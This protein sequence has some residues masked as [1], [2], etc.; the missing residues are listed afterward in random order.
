MGDA[1]FDI[2]LDTIRSGYDGRTCWVHPR[3]GAIPASH[4]GGV[5]IVVMT[6]QKLLLSGFDIFDAL[7]EMRT[8]DLGRSW[9][10]P[11]E[12]RT[13]SRRQH[14]HDLQ[15]CPCDFTPKWHAATKTLL[16]TGATALYDARNN[17][18]P[19]AAP[20]RPS[21][22]TYDAASRSWREWR[23]L[24][25][26]DTPEF[27]CTHAGCTQRVDRSDGTIFLPVHL[28]RPEDIP[29]DNM[30]A[31]MVLRCSF[32]GQ[33]LQCVEF[34]D[35]LTT[36]APGGFCEPS[37]VHFHGHYY[38]TLRNHLRGH[39]AV[40]LDGL[41]F[42]TPRPWR[43]DDGSDLG[44]Y[45]TQQH[46][47]AHGDALY[48]VYTRRGADNDHIFRHRAPLFIGRVD[49]DR[50]CVMRETERILVPQRG[51]RLGNFGV[52]EVNENETWVTVAEWMQPAGCER[53]GSD[54]SVYAARLRWA[55]AK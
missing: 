24:A 46:W 36:P 9:S 41:R 25:L 33:S 16:G 32:D 3:A 31:A 2:Q 18:V 20:S 1:S 43:F 42:D 55:V 53:Y 50:L 52:V 21:Y 4:A 49:P 37:L 7:N 10:G 26:P 13:L 51:A 19:E 23:T 35:A 17:A 34:G 11:T 6:M 14:S 44:S 40:S 8:D 30:A 39:V 27:Y 22:A 38:L 15:A 29:G 54:N 5:P 48:L 47:V 28:Q 45:Q 12:Q